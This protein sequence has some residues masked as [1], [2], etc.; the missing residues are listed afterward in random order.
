MAIAEGF[1]V[2]AADDPLIPRSAFDGLALMQAGVAKLLH[3]DVDTHH[4]P[5]ALELIESVEVLARQIDAARVE[6]LASIDRTGVHALDGHRSAKPMVANT[7]KLS[8]SEA[9]ARRK[10]ARVLD[11]LPQVAALFYSGE[12]STCMV[13]RLGRAYANPRVRDLMADADPW[14][15][16]HARKDTYEFFDLVVSQW[17][18]LADEDGAER[19]D[20]RHHRSRNHVMSQEE[21]GEW[22]WKG[23]A[24]AY[25]GA[26]TKDIFDAFEKVEFDIDAVRCAH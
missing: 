19:A 5:E 3:A 7:A 8:G 15:A 17:V 1:V 12:I 2:G 14:F 21:D 9:D 6:V 11:A 18:S 24:S 10:M 22:T 20:S 16:S 23:S 26:I 4:G 25:D 13:R